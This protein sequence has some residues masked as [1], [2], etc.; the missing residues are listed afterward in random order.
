MDIQLKQIGRYETGVF[1]EGAAEIS[2]YDSTTKRLFVVNGSTATIDVLDLSD[3]Q[4][5]TKLFEID[6]TPFGAGVNSVAIKNGVLAAAIEA[7]PSTEP[8][9]VAFFD[10]DGNPLNSVTVGSL[11]DMLTFTPDGSK[12]LV[13]NEGEPGDIVDPEGSVSIIDISSGVGSATVTTA[14]FTAFNGKEEELRSR[15]VRIFPDK[16]AASDFEPEYIAVSADSKTAFVTLQENNAVAVVD[17]EEGQVSEIKPLGVKDWSQGQPTLTQYPWDLSGNVLGTTPAGQEILLGGMSGLFF[18]KI[19]DDGKYHFIATPDRGPNGEPTD[20]DNDGTDE[21]PFPLPDYQP[22]LVRFTLDRSSGEIEIAEQIFLTRADGT[23]L[24]G[25]PNLQGGDSGSAYTDEE[26]VDLL[27]NALS[28][29]PLG[30]D[31]ESIVVAPDGTFWMSD[32]YRPAIYHF[33]ENG[34]LLDRFIPQGTADAAGEAVETFGTETLPEVYA[35]RRSN[36]GFEGMALDTDRGKLYAWIQSPIDNPDVSDA[37][38][39]VLDEK[40]D[41]NSRNSQVLRILEVDPATGTPTGEYVY[42][43]EGSKDVDKIGDAVYQGNGKFLVV[44]RDSGTDADSKKFVFEVDLTGA[45]NILGTPLS[46][47]TGT[48]T[49]LEGMT[50]DDL[51]AVGVQAV[52][53]TKVLNLP[54]LGY[55]AGDKVEGLALL[56]DGSLAIINDNDFGLLAEEV[57]GD[58]SVPFNPD[59]TQT[60]LGIIEFD[61]SNQLDASDEDGGINLKNHPVLGLYQ[62]DAIAAFSA[63]GETYY[64]TANEGDTRDEDERVADLTLDATAFPNAAELQLEENLGRLNVSS[65]DGDVDGDGD[66]DQ[67]YTYGGRS[68]SIWDSAGNLVFDSGDAIARIT[69]ELTPELFNANNG[70]PAE[71]DQRSDDKG[72]EPEGVT[73]GIVD[74]KVLAFIGL[75]RAGGGVLVYDVSNPVEPEFIQYI[76]TEGDIAPEGLTFI[77][78][79]DSPN[80]KPVL[81]LTNEVSGTTTV[82]EVEAPET[83]ETFTL[84]LL[85]AADQEAGIAALDD[86]P[87][88]SAVL[89]ALK[90]QDADGDGNAD[91]INTL[92]L[93]SGDAYIPGPFLSASETAFGGTGRGDILIQNELGFSAIAFGNHEFDL[94]TSLVSG[95]L[96]ADAETGYPGANFPYLSSNLDFTTDS[97]LAP[98]VTEDGQEASNIPG[99][100]AGNTIVTVNGEKIGVVGATTPTLPTIS[101]PGT[102][103]V[104]P[105]EFDSSNPA[106]IAALAAEIQTSVDALL[107]ANPEMNKV[108]LLAHMQQIAIEQQLSELLTDVD[109]IVAGGSNT[110]LADETDR[111]RAGDT[112]EGA[113]PILKTAADGNP[114][115]VVNTDGNYKYVGRLVVDFDANGVIIPDSIDANVSGAYATDDAGVAAVG[116]TPDPEVVEIT[117]ELRT[118]IAAQEGNIF[119]KTEVFLNGT[120]GDVRT[121][122]TNL[123]NLSADANLAY[124]QNIDSGVVISIKNGGGIRDDIGDVIVPPGATSPEDFLKVPPPANELAGKEEGDISQLDIT[125]SLRFNN[126]LSLL[127]VTASELVEI[128][129]HGV[130]ATADGATPG[131]FPQVAGIAFSFDDDLPAGDRIRSLAIQDAE[132]ETVDV[133]VENGEL[134]GDGTRTFRLVTLGFLADGGDGYPFP[135][136]DRIDLVTED[137]ENPTPEIRTGTATFAPDGSEQDAL[138]EYLSATYPAA[139]PFN[140]EDV[141]PEFDERI[142][143]LDFRNDTVLGDIVPPPTKVGTDGDDVL[144]G[145]AEEDVID[146]KGG[147]DRI[148]TGRK[149]DYVNSGDGDDKV[150]GQ[151]GDD[152]LLGGNGDDSLYGEAGDDIISGGDGNDFILAWKGNDTVSGGKGGDIFVFSASHGTDIITDFTVGED[153]IGFKQ[154]LTFA[155]LSVTTDGTKTEIAVGDE[156]LAILNGVTTPLTEVN[157]V[158]I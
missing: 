3:P 122:E 66:Y 48:D 15:G 55:I 146:G 142:Q 149:D 150:S 58:G 67:L 123:G 144:V 89:D 156:T 97:A 38:A 43:L 72:A 31:M 25:L 35:Q 139:T 56:P 130:A 114:I 59:P 119:G 26:P 2:A 20:L 153:R 49:A 74:G 141:S 158:T 80:G 104:S 148:W 69:A 75:E 9:K 29:D 98:F 107:A 79:A 62:P 87:R 28:N 90:N 152:T 120:R 125:N 136:R 137:A 92:V 45:T 14:D 103:G 78:A 84:Q 60:V 30:A 76:R 127:T 57:P 126:G 53:K 94:G 100:I 61:K 36:R 6:I 133:V 73:I 37:E 140:T 105:I 88:F 47:A 19:G 11:P 147:N 21:R 117:D 116:G 68:F 32:E 10:T 64:I 95:L 54:S 96:S 4:N 118:V 124:A 50:A 77:P 115:A 99:Q 108:V 70:D 101:S 12:I 34:V 106:D 46:S 86:A 22:R 132:G 138:A 121:Q 7:D 44:E 39:D 63:N 71:F 134:V 85:H 5:L 23:P 110:L 131:Q 18:E 13:A 128:I 129:E 157:F 143:N 51:A 151:G 27:G 33:D 135:Q 111:L 41:F 52:T 113:Y 24:T 8:G 154:G 83:P 91:Y 65:V 40:T 155:D 81:V 1:D 112:V 93:S 102:V 17:L 16:T 145:T 109:I 82:Y 42:F